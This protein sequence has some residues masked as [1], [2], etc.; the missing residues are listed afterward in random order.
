MTKKVLV[1]GGG[2]SGI[3]AAA[4]AGECGAKVSLLEKMPR[5]GSKILLSGKGR[6]NFS[7]TADLREFIAAFGPEGKFLYG[8]FSQFF[9]P[10]L[11]DLFE[12]LG[13]K[14][15]VERGGRIFPAS[16]RAPDVMKALK[17]YLQQGKVEVELNST[18]DQIEVEKG[19]VARVHLRTGETVEGQACVL[20]TGGLS[21]PDT[22]SSGDGYEI[23][24]R[25]GHTIVP[26]RPALV[27]LEVG[28]GWVTELQGLTLRNVKASLFSG[29]KEKR[30]LGEEFGELLFTHFG[31]S[32]PIILKLSRLISRSQT[33]GKLTLSLNL[34]PALGPEQLD[35]R[36]I[37]DLAKYHRRQFKHCLVD[38]LPQK[39]VAVLVR[40]SEIPPEK[41]GHSITAQERATLGNLLSNV[42]LT[43]LRTRPIEEAVVTAGGVE[44]AEVN[45]KTLESRIISGLY[46]CGEV[47]NLDGPTGGYNLQAAFSTG[48]LAGQMAAQGG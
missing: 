26:L 47:L 5:L 42:P 40:L 36:L 2:A 32:G 4:R 30:K 7:N 35:R 15:E 43:I 10:D 29:Q 8:A 41:P 13:L 12:R 20:A 6:C 44:L 28:E 11:L 16:N 14:A 33:R 37:R 18:A 9:R 21:Y 1:V 34:K 48:Y 25:L 17:R 45:P 19:K 22:G 23:A 3:M 38:L 24:R 39:L 31:V 46:F 27:P